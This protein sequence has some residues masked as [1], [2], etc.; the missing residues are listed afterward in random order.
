MNGL[1]TAAAIITFACLLTACSRQ[2]AAAGK[3]P[4]AAPAAATKVDAKKLVGKWQRPDGGY[5]L[6]IAA[7]AEDGKLDATYFNPNPINVAAAAW[8]VSDQGL[9][10]VTVE[11]RDVNYPGAKYTLRYDAANDALAGAYFQPVHNQTYEIAFVRM[12]E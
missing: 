7:A 5:V 9:L 12:N 8:R 2:P 6:A 11:L 4:A 1:K 3:E 10:I